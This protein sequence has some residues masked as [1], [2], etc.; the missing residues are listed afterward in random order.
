MTA[1]PSTMR[2]IEVTEYGSDPDKILREGTREVP[3]A[4]Q[5]KKV[6]DSRV[7]VKVKATTMNPIDY[8]IVGGMARAIFDVQFPLVIFND[9]AGVV[10]KLPEG[11]ETGFQV[12]DRVV[13]CLEMEK[14][15]A[16]HGSGGC[17]E[18][19]AVP[20]SHLTKLPSQVSCEA[21]APMGVV[22]CTVWQALCK[23]AGF[24]SATAANKKILILGGSSG[25]GLV[26][27]QLAKLWGASEIVTTS[28]QREL[29]KSLGATRVINHREGEVWNEVLQDEQ[30]D[31]LFNA[32]EGRSAWDNCGR[33]I[34]K[35]AWSGGTCVSIV[36]D[37][38]DQNF[39]YGSVF[40]MIGAILWRKLSSWFSNPSYILSL[41][42]NAS[43]GMAECVSLIAEQK[44]RLP[45]DPSGPFKPTLED[46]KRMWTLQ[47]S[48]RAHG[49]LLMLWE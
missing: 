5:G 31:V 28:S 30:F 38:P 18:F 15:R 35:S 33:G 19:C 12:G 41:D 2:C 39:T 42:T 7:L 10:A 13:G 36:P 16:K 43:E 29:C 17:A 3:V 24:N 48:G 4:S 20:V 32:V 6:S 44:L 9:F 1:L 14:E 46:A 25:C 26:A 27:I 34:V 40:Q 45:L 8:K 23:K 49:K 22:C 47:Q 21:A 37:Y 11:V